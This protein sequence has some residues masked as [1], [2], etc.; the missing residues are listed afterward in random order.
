[1]VYRTNLERSKDRVQEDN[2]SQDCK[3]ELGRTTQKLSR[4]HPCPEGGTIH[5]TRI[6]THSQAVLHIHTAS[7]RVPQHLDG[8]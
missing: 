4:S 6:Q 8:F 1:M 5:L 7:H 2:K 3:N